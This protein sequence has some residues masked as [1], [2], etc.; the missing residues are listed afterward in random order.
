MMNEG[1][2]EASEDTL[3]P[4]F[5]AEARSTVSRD[6]RL[7][8]FVA[9]DGPPALLVHSINA[10]ASAVEMRPLFERLRSA[11][12]VYAVDLPGFGHSDRSD[13]TYD[14]RLYVDAVQDMRRLIAEEKPGPLDL[15]GLSLSSE[16]AA[17]A[18]S[19]SPDGLRSLT[20]INPTGFS[21]GS[22]RLRNPGENREIPG[23]LPFARFP[24]WSEGLFNLL[25]R[26]STIRYFLRR[27]YGSR[28]VDEAMVEFDHQ[29]ARQPGAR[30]APYAFL[31]GRLFS[32][33]I[34]LVYETLELPVWVPHGTRGDF[35]DFSEAGWARAKP[36]WTFDAFTSG[37][38]PH[39]EVP[40][41]F[42]AALEAFQAKL[43]EPPA[44]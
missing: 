38:L 5:S 8:Y 43:P 18:A 40:D 41:P 21:R 10:A 17:R 24:L 7:A 1:G 35:K 33:D 39:F 14:I 13:R 12:R 6:Q 4:P 28:D 31:S 37:A 11:Y 22:E 25:T 26:K 9:G 2:A 32:K 42:F 20:L 29:S 15:Y 16:F 30:F 3:P 27:T 23:F 34:R 44:P 19:E 36:N